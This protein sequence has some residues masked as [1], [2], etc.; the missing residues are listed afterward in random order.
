MALDIMNPESLTALGAVIRKKR[1]SIG[2]TQEKLA[3]QAGYSDK[4]IRLIEHGARTKLQTLQ[5][6]CQA[7]GLPVGAYELSDN[8]IAD[9][10]YGAYNLNHY[11]DYLGVYFGFRRG[12]TN[13]TN[14]LRTVFE[15]SWSERKRCLEFYEDQKY[16][17]SAGRPVD[18]SQQGDIFINNGIGLL[19]LV[20]SDLGAVRLITLSKLRPT[21]D[22][23]EG[24]VLT[25]LRHSHYYSP[26]VSPI[27]LQKAQGVES[28]TEVS[29][30][31]GP[32]A[33]TD[34]LY[35]TV[36]AYIEEVEREVAYFPPTSSLDPKVTRISSRAAKART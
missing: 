8:K 33:P 26:A 25:Q 30:Q 7:L 29:S 17:S 18:N 9:E 15:I 35:R 20:T 1:E 2:W 12:F 6:V 16:V 27:Y 22:I 19:H 34:E 10:K 21:E 36:A 32:I 4:V 28:R 11:M 5:N 24:V 13:P 14:F 31:T 23:L 3:N